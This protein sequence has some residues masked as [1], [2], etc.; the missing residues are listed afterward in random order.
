MYYDRPEM[1][2]ELRADSGLDST[3]HEMQSLV[4]KET[5]VAAPVMVESTH[6]LYILYTSGT[7]GQPKGVV[8]DQGGTAVALNWGFKSTFNYNPG[9]RFF[10]AADIGWIVGHS[11]ILYGSMMRGCGSVIFEGKPI[12]KG[13]AGI[14]FKI[15]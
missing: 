8:R 14:T 5:E 10:G 13:D 2:G 12:L 6:P 11:M 1:D 4:D 3:F 7:T 15:C 9:H